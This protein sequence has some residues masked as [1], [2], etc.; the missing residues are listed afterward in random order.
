MPLGPGQLA[1]TAARLKIGRVGAM[2]L[3]YAPA[4]GG[5]FVIGNVNRTAG[6]QVGSPTI[7][8]VL[9]D[10]PNTCEFVANFKPLAGQDVKINY[11]GAIL[12][13]GAIERVEQTYVGSEPANIAWRATCQDY[14]RLLTRKVINTTYSEQSATA[15]AT[16]LIAGTGVS[17]FGI[18]A[19]LPTITGGIDFLDTDPRTALAK[20]AQRIGAYWY[21]DYSKVLHFFLTDPSP[22]PDPLLPTTASLMVDPPVTYEE[23]ITQLRTRVIVT[24]GG[25]T[26][27]LP[28][29]AGAS[30][31]PVEDATLFASSGELRSE[32]LRFSHTGKVA[33]GV[34]TNVGSSIAAPSA[35]PSASLSTTQVGKIVGAVSYKFS[36]KNA[37]GETLVSPASNTVTGVAFATPTAAPAI[38]VTGGL[39][40][41][42]GVYSYRIANVTDRG[43]TT[44]GPVSS[45]VAPTAFPPSTGVSI[46]AN[47]LGPLIGFYQYVCTFV[48]QY[49]ETTA[50]GVNSRSAAAVAA[51][52]GMSLSEV[53][54]TIGPLVGVYSY[55]VSFVTSLGET[56]PGGVS[57][58]TIGAQGLPAAPICVSTAVGPLVGNYSY[59]VSFVSP[60]GET[61]GIPTG[62]FNCA[63]VQAGT[64]GVFGDGTG[65]SIAYAVM[66]THPIYGASQLSGRTIDTNKGATP[67]VQFF[68]PSGCGWNVYTTGTTT[69]PAGAP[70]FQVAEM[71]PGFTSFTHTNQTGPQFTGENPSMGRW[72]QVSNI[73]Q[74]PTGTTSR[75]IYRTR[76]GGSAYFLVGEINNNASGQVFNDNAPDN[77]LT[78]QAPSVNLNGKQVTVTFIPTGP[79]GTIARRV[80][81]TKAGGSSY[82]LIGALADNATTSVLDATPDAA[83]TVNAPIT[84]TAGGEQ[85]LIGV[86][87]GPSGTLGRRL[88]RSIAG[89]SSFR[90][91]AD[92]A[93]N[94]G[95]SVLDATA[96]NQL[97]PGTV[98]VLNTAGGQNV[99]LTNIPA[100]PA[101]TLA[102]RLYRT[103]AGGSGQWFLAGQISDNVTASFVDSLPD[104]SLGRLAPLVNDAGASAVTVTIPTGPSGTAS[105]RLYRTE[106]GGSVYRFVTEI[107]DNTTG[108]H[109]DTK[110]DSE[111][112]DLPLDV[113]TIGALAGA[114]SLAVLDASGFAT[115]GWARVDSQIIT[116]S[117]RTSTTLTGIPSSGDGAIRSSISAG[118]GIVALPILTGVSGL[119][120]ALVAGAPVNLLVQRDDTPAQAALVAREGFGTGVIEYAIT[121]TNLSATEATARANAELALFSKPIGRL[122]Y[123]SRDL[124]TA[125]GKRIT[126][127]LPSLGLN[128][129][130]TIQSATI[131]EIGVA[132]G[133]NPLFTVEASTLRF[134]LEDALRRLLSGMGGL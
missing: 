45:T 73:P 97:S 120:A 65:S 36:F 132:V 55:R 81:R 58:L 98:P 112:G 14:S 133:A 86:P 95:T 85:F 114:T 94:S 31:I 78:V 53:P 1:T 39:G 80:W 16:D 72:V 77:A 107:R 128:Q 113:S 9:N 22:A 119:T 5:S 96:D 42:V 89:A 51:P 124:K 88:Y 25:S 101:G 46:T 126:V 129:T 48:T 87:I 27:L 125:S 20:L 123:A 35:A 54:N 111:L 19:G 3:R 56:L 127:N 83:L 79:T 130:F 57:S 106:G 38:G 76:A 90:L 23:D 62:T 93:D 121:D 29:A 50:G 75:R 8:D 99:Q 47:G 134:S 100:G 70:L 49:G 104:E 131:T 59:V 52:G 110:A 4:F 40:R 117:N 109:L 71:G 122:R 69:D 63:L 21:V 61:V 67:V 116:W 84:A 118:S 12:F 32:T 108:I 74:G 92:I 34:A 60:F 28:I 115:A 64:P 24:G 26:T 102:R 91:V 33:G 44:P 11:P 68:P 43:E 37:S 103:R 30:L 17:A 10:T 82:F 13:G 18:T 6:I 15:I 105:R 7:Q 41:L 2:R 66:I